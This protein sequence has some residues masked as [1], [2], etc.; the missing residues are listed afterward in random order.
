MKGPHVH[1]EDQLW[2]DV[3]HVVAEIAKFAFQQVL[4]HRHA[5]SRVGRVDRVGHQHFYSP[6]LIE[7]Q[8]GFR[9][10]HKAP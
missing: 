8:P 2:I 3:D 9:W 7:I 1:L 4:K 5:F 6:V 10:S